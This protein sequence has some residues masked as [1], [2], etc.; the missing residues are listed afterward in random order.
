[1]ISFKCERPMLSEFRV[2][3][4]MLLVSALPVSAAQFTVTKTID[5][6]DG[7]CDAD[8]SLREAIQAANSAAGA[9]EVILPHG[10]FRLSLTGAG[11]DANATGDLDI[12][13][14]LE[15]VGAGELE[16]EID[17]S[18]ASLGDRILDIWTG[19]V[20]IRDLTIKGG[21]ALGAAGDHNGGGILNRVDLTIRACTVSNNEAANGGGGVHTHADS[22]LWA[23]DTDFVDNVAVLG[24]GI[25]N[26]GGFVHLVDCEVLRN[27]LGGGIN[28]SG[29]G[30]PASGGDLIVEDTLI[31]VNSSTGSGGGVRI[32]SAH[33]VILDSSI[34]TNHADMNGGGI[35]M[36]GS[37]TLFLLRGTVSWNTATSDGG[38]LYAEDGTHIRG[39][40]FAN[41]QGYSGG[42]IYGN[43]IPLVIEDST[44]RQNSITGRFG[45]AV[46]L[47]YGGE[48][49][50]STFTLNEATANPTSGPSSGAAL[51]VNVGAS[52]SLIR[53]TIYDNTATAAAISS[54]GNLVV[55]S[56]TVVGNTATSGVA[57]LSCSSS[58]SADI[59]DSI[60][61]NNLGGADCAGSVYI[62]SSG[63]N[64]E[65]G[66]SCGFTAVGDQQSTDPM[67]GLLGSYGGPT[68]TLILLAGSPAIDAGNPSGCGDGFGG[69]LEL[70]QR[71]FAREVDGDGN[72]SA[73]CDVGAYEYTSFPARIFRDGFETRDV[74]EWSNSIP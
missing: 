52:V 42:A 20:E 7:V 60:L 73:I 74:L 55:R 25:N 21:K 3:V 9:D 19:P 56:S 5:T 13:G 63:Y 28:T 54:L 45:G 23:I 40:T 14:E 69:L 17:G 33:A 32:G 31:Q 39:T 24:G 53:S 38:G 26:W 6:F 16:T 2:A 71:A 29:A 41:N 1:M 15:I 22:H 36:S 46:Y 57:G 12:I 70:D 48:I 11:E 34:D 51:V 43:G 18:F 8:C 66:V 65:S 44:F 37:A 49:I 47:R 67:I 72:S 59:A 61:A 10:A 4:A 35:Y 64:I 62:T 30:S 68:H 27:E 58:C 50:G